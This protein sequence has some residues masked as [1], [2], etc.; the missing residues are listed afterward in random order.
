SRRR[1]SAHPRGAAP[2]L[3]RRCP[4]TASIHHCPEDFDAKHMRIR[5]AVE[6]DHSALR[7]LFQEGVIEGQVGDNDTGADIDNLRDGYFADEGQS[8][9]WVADF[10]TLVI[11]MVGV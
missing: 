6:Q 4:M 2:G 8:S 1:C 5:L 3:M 7:E 10:Q 11:G 9:F